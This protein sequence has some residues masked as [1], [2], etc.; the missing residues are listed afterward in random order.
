MEYD[1]VVHSHYVLD[2]ITFPFASSIENSG[3]L[4]MTPL[5]KTSANSLIQNPPISFDIQKEWRRSDF[6]DQAK[7]IAAV[8]EGDLSL[9]GI[10]SRLILISDADFAISQGRNSRSNADNFSLLVNS[11]DWLSDDTGLIDL[12]TKGV[13]SRP[14]EDMEDGKKNMIKWVNFLLPIVLVLF[15]GLYRNQRNKNRRLR[16]MSERYELQD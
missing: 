1:Y 13:S 14:I 10:D 9:T 16:R 8:F 4:T 2:Q 11:V 15:L 7:T 3:N 5:V 12:R 6:P